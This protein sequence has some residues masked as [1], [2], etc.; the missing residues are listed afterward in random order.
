ETGVSKSATISLHTGTNVPRCANSLNSSNDV[1]FIG[2]ELRKTF[3]GSRA[4]HRGRSGSV[5][6]P[7]KLL[8]RLGDKHVEAANRSAARGRGHCD[9][10]RRSAGTENR[11]ALARQ[12]DAEIVERPQKTGRVCV[13]SLPGAASHPDRIQRAD[14]SNRIVDLTHRIEQ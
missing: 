2:A 6:P 13:A 1:I 11:G 9:R 14:R 12:G 7:A 8:H 10:S 5:G 4:H 3:P